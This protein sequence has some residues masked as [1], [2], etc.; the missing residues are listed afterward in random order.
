[1]QVAPF[2]WDMFPANNMAYESAMRRQEG[3]ATKGR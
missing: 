1:L 3:G 2:C